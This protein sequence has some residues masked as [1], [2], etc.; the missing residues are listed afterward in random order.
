MKKTALILGAGVTGL[1]AGWASKA[2]VYEASDRPG[3][4]CASYYV[5]P[6]D[7]R[8]LARRPAD[9]EAYRFEKGG[10]H[11]IFGIQKETEKFFKGAGRLNNYRRR[12]AVFF[13][14]KNVFVPYPIQRHWRRDSG[15]VESVLSPRP[16][17]MKDWLSQTFGLELCRLFFHPFHDLY[18]DGMCAAI[19]PADLYKSPRGSSAGAGGYNRDFCYPQDGLDQFSRRLAASCDVRY[20]KEVV[21]IDV[22]K[23]RVYFSDGESLGYEKIVSTLPLCRMMRLTGLLAKEKPDPHTS[24]LILNLGARR[25]ER[26][27]EDYWI[28]VPENDLRFYRVG[29]YSNVDASF[30]PA[31]ERR[32][33]THA[34]IYVERAYSG[35]CKPAGAELA[36]YKRGVVEMLKR[37]RFIKD[38]QVL[39]DDWVEVAYTWSRPGSRWREKAL[40]ALKSH[41]IVQA[42]RF[43]RWHFQGVA[44]SLKEGW[45]AG[46]KI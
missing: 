38:A 6:G 27:P 12:A 31:S 19:A 45:D 2:P 13:P 40:R 18:T 25:A 37:W 32:V 11:W 44:D 46:K 34:A 15:K 29:F 42:G 21:R 1:A 22:G 10:G 33:K 17:T 43:A 14:K 35:G 16:R 8:R 4:L 7:K 28:Y 23:N 41:G 5:R 26:C 24:A 36:R 39:S 3:G 30:L 9:G 20:R